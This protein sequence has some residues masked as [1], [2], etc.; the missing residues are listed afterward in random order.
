[1]KSAVEVSWYRT[2]KNSVCGK[3]RCLI[4]IPGAQNTEKAEK[5]RDKLAD[6]LGDHA[7]VTRPIIKGDIRLSGFDDLVSVSEIIEIIAE[8]G[9]CLPRDIKVGEIRKLRNNLCTVW[10]QCPLTSAIKATKE[11][12]IKVGWTFARIAL[13]K[14]RPTRCFRCWHLGH[15]RN[16]C[17]SL[18]DRSAT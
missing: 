3:W 8:I 2:N 17:T 13:L 15:L 6:L 5:L 1:M 12:K 18:I 14:A 10:I 7:R 9:E 16:N 4:E 11:E